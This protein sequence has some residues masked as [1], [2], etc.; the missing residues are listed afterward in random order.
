MTRV[1]SDDSYDARADHHFRMGRRQAVRWMVCAVVIAALMGFG[2]GL[3]SAHAAGGGRTPS[4]E[5]T[6]AKWVLRWP[7][8]RATAQRSTHYP[9]IDA[10]T[11]RPPADPGG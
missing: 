7:S 6:H 5:Q 4:V 1:M 8:V 10:A 2:L 11:H 3:G 9:T